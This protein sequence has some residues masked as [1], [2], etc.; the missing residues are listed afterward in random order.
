MDKILYISHDGHICDMLWETLTI[1]INKDAF[2]LTL[3]GYKN[4]KYLRYSLKD[5][6]TIYQSIVN[7]INLQ[8][9][10]PSRQLQ[11]YQREP[12]TRHDV[13][14]TVYYIHSVV[15]TDQWSTRS[16]LFGTS[17]HSSKIHSIHKMFNTGQQHVHTSVADS[18]HKDQ[19]LCHHS[20]G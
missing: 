5:G 9:C 19:T 10:P 16:T 7:W 18:R 1:S 2:R 17:F 11:R 3:D 8:F 4:D 13:T 12:Y 15:T 14:D 6:D 20:W